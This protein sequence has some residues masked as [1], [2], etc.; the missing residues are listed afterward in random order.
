MQHGFILNENFCGESQ[1]TIASGQVRQIRE[2][3]GADAF[4]LMIIPDGKS[5]LGRVGG[6]IDPILSQA[7]DHLILH[8][9]DHGQNLHFVRIINDDKILE[10]FMGDILTSGYKA[11]VEA[12]FR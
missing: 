7:G 4:A 12:V 2:E 5:H 1:Q 9:S 3:F 11:P 6:F 8:I 10:P